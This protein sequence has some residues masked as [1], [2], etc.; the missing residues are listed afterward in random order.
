[1]GRSRAAR[2]KSLRLRLTSFHKDLSSHI[3]W[4]ILE[5]E[6]ISIMPQ[7]YMDPRVLETMLP[8][9]PQYGNAESLHKKGQNAC[10]A[11]DNSCATIAKIF[12]C[13]PSEIPLTGGGTEA[14]NLAI[15]GVARQINQ[16]ATTS[17]AQ[18]SNILILNR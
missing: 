4:K 7:Q 17:L 1:M 14:N 2:N 9:F 5:S 12:N 13:Q 11:V 18:T 15:F 16:K 3:A 10:M 8:I 6:L